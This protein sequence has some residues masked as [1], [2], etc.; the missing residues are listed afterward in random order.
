[1][2][3]WRHLLLILMT[4]LLEPS[5]AFAQAGSTGGNVGKQDKSVSGGQDESA[6]P[7]STKK[8]S[9]KPSRSAT[10]RAQTGSLGAYSGTWGGVSTGSCILTWSW[11]AQISSDGNMSGS[12]IVGHVTRGGAVNGTMTVV[13]KAYNFVG[14]I[15]GGAASGTWTTAAGCAGRWTAA[16]S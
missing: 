15:A 6:Q 11:T 4:L 14:R 5:G 12:G 2:R 1:M 9:P 3:Q 10:V 13:G 8:A 7:H 16:K